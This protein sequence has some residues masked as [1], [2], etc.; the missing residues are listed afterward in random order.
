MSEFD[1]FHFFLTGKESSYYVL[2]KREEGDENNEIKYNQ[3]LNMFLMEIG[4]SILSIEKNGDHNEQHIGEFEISAINME[5]KE[6]EFV[7][8]KNSIT[9]KMTLTEKPF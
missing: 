9:H 4:Y 1:Q 8:S 6:G 3:A 5:D 7:M 2:P